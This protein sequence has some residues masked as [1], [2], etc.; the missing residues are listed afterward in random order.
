MKINL[1]NNLFLKLISMVSAV[2][3]WVVVVS[4]S[5]AEV[6]E[7]FTKEVTLL[8]TEAITES[9][10]VFRIEEGSNIVKLKVEARKSVMQDLDESDFVLT[11]DM[12][13]NLKYGKMVVI[14]V[15]CSNKN[16]DVDRDVTLLRNNV[17]VSIEESATEQFPIVTGHIGEPNQGLQVG[18]IVPEQ[19]VVKISGPI[20]IVQKIKKVEAIVDI[21][22][23]PGDAVRNCKLRLKDGNGDVI[24]TTYLEFAGKT[25]GINV[26]IS[27][28]KTKVAYLMVSSMGKPA[29]GF[30]LKSI[31]WKP[32]S[33]RIA[34]SEEV[35]SEITSVEIPKEAVNIDGIAEELQLVIDL[36]EYLP[37]G[38]V[39]ADEDEA[40]VLVV[41]EVEKNV[42]AEE[43]EKT[44]KE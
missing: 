37:S 3:L 12:E 42:S 1:E 30:S 20:S 34:G 24:D 5:D 17:E 21:T 33:I 22:G 27:M 7:T 36:K 8:N 39:L 28:F 9:G 19:T 31:T 15:K 6:T 10:N 41:V 29:K 13:K 11:A 44:I 40:S 16:I 2:V 38:V 4:I 43:S 25:E 26:K 18:E 32:K 23:V 35:L 14:D